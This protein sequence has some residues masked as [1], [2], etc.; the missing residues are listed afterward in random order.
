MD[1]VLIRNR[2]AVWQLSLCPV[3]FFETGECTIG[4]VK[5]LGADSIFATTVFFLE[6]VLLTSAIS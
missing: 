3:F 2:I 5:T 6:C 4:R 1:I